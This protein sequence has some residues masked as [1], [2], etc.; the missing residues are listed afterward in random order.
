MCAERGEKEIKYMMELIINFS[1][2]ILYQDRLSNYM[3]VHLFNESIERN[4]NARTQFNISLVLFWKCMYC[5]M[6]LA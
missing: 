6:T 4:I 3:L 2:R 1:S 5:K